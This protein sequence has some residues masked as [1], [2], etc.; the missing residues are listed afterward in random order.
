MNKSV[1]M[2]GV[3]AAAAIGGTAMALGSMF[4]GK[5]AVKRTIKKTA[6]KAVKTANAVLDGMQGIFG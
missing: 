6:A 4:S 1:M 3:G 5:R 2:A